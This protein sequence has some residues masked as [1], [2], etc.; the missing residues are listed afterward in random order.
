[1]ANLS[2]AATIAQA[3]FLLALVADADGRTGDQLFDLTLAFSAERTREVDVSI[4]ATTHR[5][6]IRR[7][8]RRSVNVS[9]W[10]AV[11]LTPPRTAATT[12]RDPNGSGDLR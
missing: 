3:V 5:E 8:A 12:P 10:Y 4:V 9:T 2:F 7:Q 11:G 6:I 1:M